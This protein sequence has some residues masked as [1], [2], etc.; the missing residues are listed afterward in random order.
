MKSLFITVLTLLVALSYAQEKA[1]TP[2]FKR[3]YV[4]VS[5]MQGVSYRLL[6]KNKWS[7]SADEPGFMQGIE[8]RN[9]IETPSYSTNA[10]IR[11]GIN[12]TKFLSFE[13]GIEY[14]RKGY[15]AR[16]EMYGY[17]MTEGFGWPPGPRE[18]ADGLLRIQAISH[19]V[20]IPVAVNFSIGKRKLRAL[21][22][23]GTYF[24]FIQYKWLKT[25]YMHEGEPG[26]Y[27]EGGKV[28]VLNFNIVPFLGVGINYQFNQF[29]NLNV[30]PVV[31]F[32]AMNN[33]QRL[34]STKEYLYSGG[35]NI[36][37]NFGFI[38]V[39]PKAKN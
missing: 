7:R 34:Y 24:S 18:K 31:Q 15:E 8:N 9:K 30:M 28:D 38:D 1:A 26:K 23:T 35:I 12:A 27:I 37:L 22:S 10:G 21:V 33:R 36:A 5:T 4:G 29:M 17:F 13:T 3:V 16:Q 32:Q 2:S 25:T 39:T 20:D 11:L 19:Y 14:S 6:V